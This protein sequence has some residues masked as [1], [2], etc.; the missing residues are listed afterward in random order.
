MSFS[1]FFGINLYMPEWIWF[2]RTNG[3]Y[4]IIIVITIY[5]IFSYIA[6]YFI[7]K[8][9]IELSD[10]IEFFVYEPIKFIFISSLILYFS[11]FLYQTIFLDYE[12]GTKS[13]YYEGLEYENYFKYKDN[14]YKY[15]RLSKKE[16]ALNN[17]K[18]AKEYLKKTVYYL[19]KAKNL[20]ETMHK[21]K[22]LKSD[23]KRFVSSYF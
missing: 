22:H 4:L 17:E 3:L 7:K 18:K 10:K 13:L 16:E 2:F 6:I 19:K 20:E 8:T 12:E 9:P 14:Y 21:D 5:L 11:I 15:L 1:N 23:I